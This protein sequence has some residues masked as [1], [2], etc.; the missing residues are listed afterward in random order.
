MKTKWNSKVPDQEGWYWV[1]Y[2]GKRG[3]VICPALVCIFDSDTALIHTARN[4]MFRGERLEGL[5]FGPIIP[6]PA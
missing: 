1:K 3:V 4:D 2:K 6:F 5:K